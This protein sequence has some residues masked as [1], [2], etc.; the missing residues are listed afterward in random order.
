MNPTRQPPS[1]PT[2]VADLARTALSTGAARPMLTYYDQATGE[3][4]ELSGVSLGNWVAKTANLLVDGCGLAP[5]APVGVK[6]PPHW[7]TAAVL[8]GCWLAGVVVETDSVDGLA[9]LPSDA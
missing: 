8:L 4:T 2:T 9:G 3:R 7:Q 1:D 5:D 6:L